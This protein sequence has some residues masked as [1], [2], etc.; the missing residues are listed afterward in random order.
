MISLD[1]IV[2]KFIATV[3]AEPE[4]FSQEFPKDVQFFRTISEI[5]KKLHMP[6]EDIVVAVPG[7]TALTNSDFSLTVEEITIRYKNT[8]TIIN[9][10]IVG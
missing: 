6:P 5:A 8:F 4:T 7:G 9:R 1:V 2:L 3:G 10:G